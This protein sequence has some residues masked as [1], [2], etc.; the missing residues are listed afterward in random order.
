MA[1]TD[2]DRLQ[3]LR[4]DVDATLL[5]RINGMLTAADAF[6]D[7]P[8]RLDELLEKQIPWLMGT[9]HAM[10]DVV[11]RLSATEAALGSPDFDPTH[12]QRV[13]TDLL[14]TLAALAT[15]LDRGAPT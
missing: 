4:D 1:A 2:H 9:V 3:T 11:T 8:D 12:M 6:A 15:E 10:R 14:S 7:D 13:R 5:K